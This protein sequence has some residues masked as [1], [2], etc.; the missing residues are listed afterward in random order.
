MIYGELLLIVRCTFS[1]R[2]DGQLA[3]HPPKE[4]GCVGV[5]GAFNGNSVF[6]EFNHQVSIMELFN[7]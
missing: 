6:N 5:Y 2:R 3:S 1:S 7:A 4:F